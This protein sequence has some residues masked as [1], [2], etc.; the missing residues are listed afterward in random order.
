MVDVEIRFEEIS[1]RAGLDFR[2]VNGARRPEDIRFMYQTTGGGVGVVDFDH[3]G[4]PDLWWT[5]G[6]T[7][8][9]DS[10]GSH[11]DVLYLNTGDGQLLDVSLQAGITESRFSQGLAVGDVDCDGFPDVLV[12]NLIENQLWMNNGDGTFSASELAGAGQ[13][14]WTTSC[15]VADLDG[16]GLPLSLIHI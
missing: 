3:N 12:A 16:D 5:Q 6:T 13:K 10:D 1:E 7:R 2:F 8:P 9:T 11:S 15:L 4:W 14:R